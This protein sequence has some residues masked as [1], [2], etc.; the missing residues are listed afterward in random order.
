MLHVTVDIIQ[1]NDHHECYV[2]LWP[3]ED[4]SKMPLVYEHISLPLSAL[5]LG[6]GHVPIMEAVSTVCLR[7]AENYDYPLF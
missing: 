5:P 3:S 4:T 2:G 6:G 1:R 7:I